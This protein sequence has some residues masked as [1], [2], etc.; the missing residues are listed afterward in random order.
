MSNPTYDYDLIVI[1]TGPS[2]QKAAI[3]AAQL[4]KKVAVVE[5]RMEIGGVCVNTGT[6]PS[7]TI[8]EAVIKLTGY[9]ERA[10]HGASYRVKENITVDDLL[11]RCN[12]VIR[13]EINILKNHFMSHN[14]DV[15]YGNARFMDPHTVEYESPHGPKEATAENI[16]IA[17][18]TVP[19]DPDD[20][21]ID[22]DI[23]LNS[24]SIL[25]LHRIPKNIIVIGGGVIGIEYAS[26]FATLGVSVTLINR[27]DRMLRFVDSEIIDSLVNQMR[28]AGV[29]I[30]AP[31]ELDHV[32]VL[33]KEPRSAA[34]Y[35]K[36]KKVVKADSVLFALGRMGATADLN[37]EAAGLISDKRG[38][39]P[40]N[41]K[42]KTK[43]DHI[44]AVGDVIG[45][46]SL[47]STSY[48]QGRQAAYYMFD[49][50]CPPIPT[51]FPYGIYSIPE[52]SY[53]GASELELTEKGIPYESG[54]ARYRETARGQ[55][56]GDFT[57]LLKLL[58]DTEDNKILGVH[59]IGTGAT[60][61]IHIGQAIMGLGGTLDFIM[62]AVF[63]YP[64]LAECYKIAAQD[65]YNKLHYR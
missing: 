12:K 40:V 62:D 35:L 14:I 34:V 57:G 47:A 64:T 51:V 55:I 31:E 29:T 21:G 56:L 19:R 41:E 3:I 17:V 37:L 8:R 61:I 30:R 25:K 63:N 28:E 15:L 27:S 16:I 32:E 5:R 18:G 46:P 33:S 1:G 4:G 48:E 54:I 44:Y 10:F 39:I 11:S 49:H 38:L 65:V 26:I 20:I 53:V 24:D 23:I 43:A 7:K 52:I 13:R 58:V 36:S 22:D 45:F 6:I 50:S 9:T 42:Y 60:E 2:G 59:A